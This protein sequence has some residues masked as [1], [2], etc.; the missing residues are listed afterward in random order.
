MGTAD[1]LV[2]AT[3]GNARWLHLADKVGSVKPGLLADLIAVSGNPAADIGNLRRI[4]MVMKGGTVVL[5]AVQ[6]GPTSP[7]LA[8][9]GQ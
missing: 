7:G 5:N 6:G 4:R 9:V 3:S 2:A 8:D 1:V